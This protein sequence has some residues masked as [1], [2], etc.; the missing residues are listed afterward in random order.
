[1][2]FIIHVMSNSMLERHFYQ[3]IYVSIKFRTSA[4]FLIFAVY[5]IFLNSKCNQT[6]HSIIDVKSA[7]FAFATKLYIAQ[8][9][10]TE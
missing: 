7:R 10:S 6:C 4:C 3:Q 1:M 2:I 8:P 5:K 9:L